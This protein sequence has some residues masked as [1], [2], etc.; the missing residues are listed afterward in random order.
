M[1]RTIVLCID[2][3]D[4]LGA[5]TGI[6]GPIIGETRCKNAA[7]KLLL[8]DPSESDANAIFAA[9]K[10]KR[11]LKNSEVAIL[12]GD[13][14]LGLKSDNAIREQL[15]IVIKKVKPKEAII[16]T[17]GSSDEFIIPIIQSV[18]P[19]ASI[20]RVVVRQ[21]EKVETSYYLLK[22]YWHEIISQPERARVILGIPAIGL[23]ILAIFGSA[24]ISLIL[25]TIGFYL[26]IKAFQFESFFTT[27]GHEL[28]STLH[29]GRVTFFLYVLSF[30]FL[31]IGI[32]IGYRKSV[33]FS[34]YYD[35]TLLLATFFYAATPFLFASAFLFLTGKLFVKKIDFMIYLRILTLVFGISTILYYTGEYLLTPTIGLVN[36]LFAIFVSFALLTVVIILEQARKLG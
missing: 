12:T 6:K 9:I 28:I 4:D 35:I 29:K 14:A 17:D 22:S 31:A 19:I 13:R 21:S 25:A 30:I 18:I 10:T 16:V 36:I 34:M 24:G 1:A 8:V 26:L 11:S 3:D 15:K 2:R 20:Q 7:V 23:I 5:K 33:I 32:I 27:L